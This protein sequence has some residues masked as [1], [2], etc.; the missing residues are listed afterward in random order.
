M[1]Y[2]YIRFTS[3]NPSTTD[4]ISQYDVNLPF[5]IENCISAH[6]KSFSMPN[7]AYNVIEGNNIINWYETTGDGSI[8]GNPALLEASIKPGYYNIEHLCQ[9]IQA[10]MN[11]K[12]EAAVGSQ[13]TRKMVFQVTQIPSS[14]AQ[15]K[16]HIQ[17]IATDPIGGAAVKK[18][19]IVSYDATIWSMLGFKEVF[20]GTAIRGRFS[21]L[22][23][24]G[25]V[26]NPI[27]SRSDTRLTALG[28]GVPNSSATIVAAFPPRDSHESYHITSSLASAVNECQADNGVARHTNYLLTV[29]NT[30]QRYSWLQY[31]PTEPVFHDLKG[32][33]LNHF[34]IGLADENGVPMNNSEHQKFSV[35]I[36]IEYRDLHQ[37]LNDNQLRTLEWRQN[38]C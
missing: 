3:S 12:S 15:N 6:V 9:V 30:S 2:H 23:S 32:I 33:N 13:T 29:P 38:R 14:T 7:T 8:N 31:I 24:A 5:P 10:A 11:E 25:N 1:P 21:S 34:T 16:Y 4:S 18:F 20:Q 19:A 26:S 35:V 37:T 28:T 27:T 17:I 36:A 22:V